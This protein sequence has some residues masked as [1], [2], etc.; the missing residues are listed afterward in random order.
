MQE[1]LF[2]KLEDILERKFFEIYKKNNE[3]RLDLINRM[4]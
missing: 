4:F 3:A 1:K 2:K